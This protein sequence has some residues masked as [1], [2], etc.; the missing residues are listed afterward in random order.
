M[1]VVPY[2]CLGPMLSVVCA[3]FIET[4]H[5]RSD[6]VQLLAQYSSPSIRVA[7]SCLLFAEAHG[8]YKICNCCGESGGLLCL[9]FC[10]NTV[11]KPGAI[12]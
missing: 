4:L 1:C 9:G 8:I 7:C 2:G 11:W 3:V 12:D 6:I 10:C 5:L